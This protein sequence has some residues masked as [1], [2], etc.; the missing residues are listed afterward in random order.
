[1]C[2]VIIDGDSHIISPITLYYNSF[3]WAVN[4]KERCWFPDRFDTEYWPAGIPRENTLSAFIDAY[5]TNG[6]E[7]CPTG[8]PNLEFSPN[9]FFVEKIAIYTIDGRPSHACRQLNSGRWTSK[10]GVREDVEH[11][12]VENF[13]V[14]IEGIINSLGNLNTIMRRIHD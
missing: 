4:D 11:E 10:I 12:L 8:D 9:G 14:E 1:M 2:I 5:S 13:I 3:A 6:F 7:V